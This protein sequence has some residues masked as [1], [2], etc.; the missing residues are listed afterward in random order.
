MPVIEAKYSMP[1]QQLNGQLAGLIKFVKTTL[2][3]VDW[4]TVDPKGNIRIDKVDI[5]MKGDQPVIIVTI[6]TDN[7]CRLSTPVAAAKKAITN[8][9][10]NDLTNPSFLGEVY[11]WSVVAVTTVA[12]AEGLQE[13]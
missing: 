5:I 2:N 6:K 9:A 13:M 7:L 11:S 10:K 4:D 12:D 3:G 1:P 8:A